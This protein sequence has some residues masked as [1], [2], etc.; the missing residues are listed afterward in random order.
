MGI[1]GPRWELGLALVRGRVV[2]SCLE[3]KAD[4]P[5]QHSR[6]VGTG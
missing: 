3:D 2:Q 6:F 1:Q 4:A 5:V